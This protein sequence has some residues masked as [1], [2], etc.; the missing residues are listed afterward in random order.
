MAAM[1]FFNTSIARKDRRVFVFYDSN[2]LNIYEFHDIQ[3]PTF[4]YSGEAFLRHHYLTFLTGIRILNTNKVTKISQFM[5]VKAMMSN[6]KHVIIFGDK[7]YCLADNT[8]YEPSVSHSY[9][10]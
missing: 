3:K 2:Q 4:T 7:E 1:D 6:K 5:D 10:L 8:K 9:I